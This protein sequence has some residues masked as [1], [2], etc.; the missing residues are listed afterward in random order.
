MILRQP[1]NHLQKKK[2]ITASTLAFFHLCTNEPEVFPSALNQL[3][4]HCLQTESLQRI[5]P[6]DLLIH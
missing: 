6:I 1:S 4:Y 2:I 3:K 5:R